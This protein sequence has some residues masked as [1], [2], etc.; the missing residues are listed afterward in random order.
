MESAETP[1]VVAEA[2]RIIRQAVSRPMSQ[3]TSPA[4]QPEAVA[5]ESPSHSPEPG[6]AAPMG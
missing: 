6:G 5:S 4:K 3:R 1:M 2:L